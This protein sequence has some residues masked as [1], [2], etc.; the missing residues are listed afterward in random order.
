MAHTHPD[1]ISSQMLQEKSVFRHSQMSHDWAKLP[2]NPTQHWP[3]YVETCLLVSQILEHIFEI[4][5]ISMILALKHIE[6][7]NYTHL[8]VYLS[9]FLRFVLFPGKKQWLLRITCEL[10]GQLLKGHITEELS[11]LLAFVL[12][13]QL[14]Y[15]VDF[16]YK[17][18][19]SIQQL[20]HPFI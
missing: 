6:G 17:V 20:V 14:A 13:H 1:S 7:S 5:N 12:I 15:S 9:N 4:I 10:P 3:L 8:W 11:D 2:P 18:F 16:I 19:L